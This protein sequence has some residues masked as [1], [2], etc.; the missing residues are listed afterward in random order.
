MAQTET[1]EQKPTYRERLQAKY[2]DM[3]AQTD[4]DYAAMSEKYLDDTESELSRYRDSEAAVSE[5]IQADPEFEAVVTDM[6]VDGIPFRVALQRHIPVEEL[7]PVEGDDDYE[8]WQQAKSQRLAKAAARAEQQKQIAENEVASSKLFNEYAAEKNMTEQE[9]DEFL[10]IINDA[11][12][13]LLYKKIDKKFLDLCFKGSR[14]D[15]AVEEAEQIGEM[16]GRNSAIEAKMAEQ[17][18]KTSGDGIPGSIGGSG[19]MAQPKKRKTNSFFNGIR[20]HKDF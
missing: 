8:Q 19:A 11:L 7:T 18:S 1:Q 4:E 12:F 5:L 6:L 15:K 2:P 14:F 3:A 13:A 16:N 20:E 9:K 17:T 10:S